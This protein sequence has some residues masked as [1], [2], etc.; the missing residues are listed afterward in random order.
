MINNV[1]ISNRELEILQLVAYEHSTKEIA[2]QLYI[3]VHTVL[4]HRKN[5]LIKMEAKNTA[6]LVRRG[7]EQGLLQIIVAA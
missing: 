1:T 3:S 2:E 7:F 6:G 5:L 4:S